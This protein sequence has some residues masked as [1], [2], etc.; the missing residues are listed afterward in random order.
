MYKRSMNATAITI[1]IIAMIILLGGTFISYYIATPKDNVIIWALF[2]KPEVIT[3]L[4]SMVLFAFA[5]II[6]IL[7]DMRNDNDEI[8]E[9]LKDIH[10]TNIE[11][12][13]L[14]SSI[15]NSNSEKSNN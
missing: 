8:S 14:L 10:T 7:H 11:L 1:E 4:S 5:E 15:K 12:I 6:K 3:V 9:T 2:F 13:K